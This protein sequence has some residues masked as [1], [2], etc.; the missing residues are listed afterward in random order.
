LI[1][2]AWENCAKAFLL[3]H[4]FGNVSSDGEERWFAGT[5]AIVVKFGGGEN[6]V[7]AIVKE[8]LGSCLS[9]I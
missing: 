3:W 7:L 1:L 8:F 5:R 9:S 6:A 4:S 2:E